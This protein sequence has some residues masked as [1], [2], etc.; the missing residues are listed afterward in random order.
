MKSIML[1]LLITLTGCSWS[2][3]EIRWGLASCVATGADIHT[4]TR[5]LDNPNNYERN[6]IMGR[7]PS[8]ATVISYMITS[9]ILVLTIAHF[10]PEW[11]KWILGSKTAINFAWAIN[12]TQLDWDE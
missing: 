10:V 12:N 4:T 11:R 2:K 1:I 8:D 6:P 5:M 7:H 3:S 9:Q